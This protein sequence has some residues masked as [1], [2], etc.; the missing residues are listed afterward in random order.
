MQGVFIGLNVPFQRK[1]SINKDNKTNEYLGNHIVFNSLNLLKI[2]T[3]L[4]PEEMKWASQR[5]S[6]IKRNFQLIWNFREATE[7][8]W[9]GGASTRPTGRVT[10]ILSNIFFSALHNLEF[11][12]CIEYSAGR[13]L[14]ICFGRVL[15]SLDEWIL[16]LDNQ[17]LQSTCPM[18]KCS[19]K[20]VFCPEGWRSAARTHPQPTWPR[21][22]LR[23][24]W[25][26]WV[27]YVAGSLPYCSGGFFFGLTSSFPLS[28]KIST[29]KFQFDLELT[30]TFQVF[31]G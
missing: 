28:S 6:C 22:T 7:E 13:N 19:E 20:K 25:H 21:F 1:D 26:M 27:E 11:I 30:D 12:A 24:R 10:F 16:C 9:H 29:S 5:A 4:L 15:F 23:G 17:N 3:V 31:R 18:D 8:G 14:E 2:T